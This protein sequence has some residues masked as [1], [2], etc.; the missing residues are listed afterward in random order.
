MKSNKKVFKNLMSLPGTGIRLNQDYFRI[1]VQEGR[2]NL[3]CPQCSEQL[4]PNDVESLVGGDT[5]LLQLYQFLMVRRVL[6][7]DPDT[8]YPYQTVRNTSVSDQYQCTGCSLQA[9]V[10]Q[11]PVFNINADTGP[12]KKLK[13]SLKM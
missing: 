1:E 2:A 4:H 7:A 12:S 5:S 8:R 11:D 6:A 13:L 10:K 3:K 9:N